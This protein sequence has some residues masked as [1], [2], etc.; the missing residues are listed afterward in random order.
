M[1]TPADQ[2]QEVYYEAALA[3]QTIPYAVVGPALNS[4]AVSNQV[5]ARLWAMHSLFSMVDS[6]DENGKAAYLAAVAP[7]LVDPP[8]D[9]AFAADRL[10]NAIE[11]H[12]KA[13]E[14]VP[15]L[16]AMLGSKEVDVRRAAAA[17]L[18]DI[19][20]PDVVPPLA[21]LALNDSDERVRFLAVRGLAAA[22]HVTRALTLATF[23][24]Q[25][26]QLMQFWR[27]WAR[28]NVRDQ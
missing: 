15:T 14:A 21:R 17:V 22:T 28:A 9:L 13:P 10:A 1:A 27:D 19:A 25:K 6:D 4:L 8:P 5:P 23:D 11:S 2:G 24:R 26:D 12:L 18:R 16:A 3:L 7:I 20:T